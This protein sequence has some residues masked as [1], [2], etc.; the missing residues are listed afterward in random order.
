MQKLKL[1]F[2]LATALFITSCDNNNS[3][4]TGV[5]SETN[6]AAKGHSESSMVPGVS[7]KNA[8]VAE[9][10]VQLDQGKKWR[11]NAETTEGIRKMI[12]SVKGAIAN[13]VNDIAGYRAL[14]ASLQKDFNAI[15][16]KCTMTGDAHEQLH[17]YLLPMVDM[18]KTFESKDAAACEK[19]L[20]E[21]KEHLGNYYSYFE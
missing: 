14:G 20:P 13:E 21:L 18:V 4:G 8:S 10:S 17:N 11:A 16:E 1:I 19:A 3:A 15:F 5:D 2:L 7:D 12:A 9:F 6:A